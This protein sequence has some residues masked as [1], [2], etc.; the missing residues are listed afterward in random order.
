V[1]DGSCPFTNTTVLTGLVASRSD[2]PWSI[3]PT[4][5]RPPS[6]ASVDPTEARNAARRASPSSNP[7]T[8]PARR[9]KEWLSFA[10]I[11]SDPWS[12]SCPAPSVAV[13]ALKPGGEGFEVRSIGLDGQGGCARTGP[14]SGRSGQSDRKRVPSLY[15]EFFGRSEA[16]GGDLYVE[17]AGK[18]TYNA[19]SMISPCPER[20]PLQ[21]AADLRDRH[22][23]C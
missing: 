2:T 7:R 4:R 13:G 19:I 6:D 15:V 20:Q 21:D 10:C 8:E 11:V 1:P 9:F 14:G 5:A 16:E 23:S 18:S 17:L 12:S 3:R 22:V